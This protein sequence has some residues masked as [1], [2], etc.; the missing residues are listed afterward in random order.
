MHSSEKYAVLIDLL[1]NTLPEYKLYWRETYLFHLKRSV[2]KANHEK[3]I[4]PITYQVK[5]AYCNLK[6]RFKDQFHIWNLCFI[7]TCILFK[8]EIHIYPIKPPWNLLTNTE[9][10]C[11]QNKNRLLLGKT[12]TKILKIPVILC[13]CYRSKIFNK[14]FLLLIIYISCKFISNSKIQKRVFAFTYLYNNIM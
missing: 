13:E 14:L 2:R 6:R 7:S 10:C 12:R 4:S 1:E 11:K 8:I 9:V 3:K 5:V